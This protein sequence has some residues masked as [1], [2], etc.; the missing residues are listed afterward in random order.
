MNL[1]LI[2][3]RGNV[4]SGL[5]LSPASIKVN[6]S[7]GI[8]QPLTITASDSV[9]QGNYSLIVQVIKDNL[10]KEVEL[11]VTVMQSLPDSILSAWQLGTAEN[12]QAIALA[13]DAGGNIIVAGYTEGSL[14]GTS[15]GKSDALYG[16][17]TRR[18]TSSGRGNLAQ[19]NWIEPL[20][21]P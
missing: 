9:P 16:I 8:T 15:A 14:S 18:G 3:T 17:T 11:S 4:V 2:D 1:S 6:S 19:M 5:T 21:L 7:Q 20:P 12:D 10:Y 13:V